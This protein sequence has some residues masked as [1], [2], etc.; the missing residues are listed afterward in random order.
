[1]PGYLS[2]QLQ[3]DRMVEFSSLRELCRTPHYDGPVV[4]D[5]RFPSKVLAKSYREPHHNLNVLV[6][7]VHSMGWRNTQLG[8][9]LH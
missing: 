4:G 9:A 3:I 1:M 2:N 8:P 6:K 5:S 7:A